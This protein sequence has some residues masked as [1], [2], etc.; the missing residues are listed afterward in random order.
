MSHVVTPQ[1]TPNPNAMRFQFEA[2]V[3]G[4]TS[5][6]I[7]EANAAA[8]KAWAVALFKVPGVHSLFAVNDFVTVT[9]A[10]DAEWAAI[11]PH[12]LDILRDAEL[13]G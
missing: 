6:A 8:G 1:P 4:S 5:H 13:D 9:K 10:N 3:F 7:S 11:T 12:V 2:G